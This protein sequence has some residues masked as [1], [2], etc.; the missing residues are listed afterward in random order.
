M[1]ALALA[2]AFA[3]GNL[4][5]FSF[6]SPEVRI[7][8]LDVVVF[9]LT[10]LALP[11]N[12]KRY[13]YLILPIGVFFTLGLVSL[14]LAL[15]VYGW[16]A[17][18]VGSLYL[19]RWVVYSLFFASIIQ[20][21]KSS[22]I[23]PLLYSLGLITAILSLGQYF[24]FPDVRALTVA[25]WDPHYFRVVGT[26]LDPGFTGIILV[27]TLILLVDNPLGWV[28]V[29]PALALTYSRSSYL[30]FLVSMAYLAWKRKGWRFFV[31]I[32]LLFTLTLTLLPRAPDGEGVKLERT[33]SIQARID[34]W[35]T[36]WKIFTQHP[37]LGVGFNTYR[38]AQGASLKS[39]AGAGTDSSLLFVAATT[40][41]LGL[42][43]YL[44]YLKR[45][46]S[47]TPNSYLLA[48]L[49]HSIFL[50]SLFYPAVMVW[51]ALLLS[52]PG[53]RPGPWPQKPSL[54]RRG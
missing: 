28:V 1:A 52:V 4:Y 48:L 22:K 17:I 10:L 42:L 6:F 53:F 25:E 27:F 13:R 11:L 37:I 44:W 24:V 30:A 7:S 23:A 47:L 33:N 32:L 9:V 5:K 16:Q 20:L 40:G 41:I 35:T 45:L 54:S 36:A 21:I 3:F 34:S 2:L 26:W 14:I 51:I 29:Y 31:K 43:A 19:A 38:Y 18:F 39:H 49:V 15:P 46:F 50:N 12:F 8:A